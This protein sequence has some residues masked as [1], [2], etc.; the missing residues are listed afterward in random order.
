MKSG[1][2]E[3]VAQHYWYVFSLL[4]E[5]ASNQGAVSVKASSAVSKV[6]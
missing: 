3:M 5:H 4:I 2:Y 6:D 1:R